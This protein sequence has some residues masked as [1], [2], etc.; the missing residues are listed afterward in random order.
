MFFFKTKFEFDVKIGKPNFKQGTPF[1]Y[2]F[3][4]LNWKLNK[5]LNIETRFGFEAKIK[6]TREVRFLQIFDS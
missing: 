5:S 4:N 2:D 6:E 3:L 1:F